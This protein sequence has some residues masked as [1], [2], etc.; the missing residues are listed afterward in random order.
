MNIILKKLNV[1]TRTTAPHPTAA[2]VKGSVSLTLLYPPA[3]EEKEKYTLLDQQ[4][5]KNMLPLSVKFFQM[6]RLDV[7][8]QQQLLRW[9]LHQRVYR[10]GKPNSVSPVMNFRIQEWWRGQQQPMHQRAAGPEPE[11]SPAQG[12]INKIFHH[13]RV[14]TPLLQSTDDFTGAVQTLTVHRWWSAALEK[15]PVVS[16][17]P[18]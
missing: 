7:L 11:S 15:G 1:L 12:H 16:R 14:Y 4:K 2:S 18:F 13:G 17:H 6:V 9:Q 10:Q 3:W 8:S 5:A